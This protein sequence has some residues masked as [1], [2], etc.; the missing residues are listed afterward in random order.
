MFDS[1]EV[2]HNCDQVL[3][4]FV[5]FDDHGCVGIICPKCSEMVWLQNQCL[6]QLHSNNDLTF[7]KVDN[8]ICRTLGVPC[9]PEVLRQIAWN[10]ENLGT[11]G[12]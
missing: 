6:R 9:S 5:A 1:V 10:E 11:S 12:F 3:G 7:K 8:P 4:I 2:T